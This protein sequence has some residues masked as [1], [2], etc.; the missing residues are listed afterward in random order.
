MALKKNVLNISTYNHSAKFIVTHRQLLL[1]VARTELKARYAGSI[2]GLGWAVA[3]PLLMLIIYALVYL[4][5]F[6]IRVPGLSPLQYVLLIFSG[7]VPFFTTSE[8]LVS[9][10]S[11]VVSNK[12][13]LS[14]TVFPI[15]LTPV[16]AVLLSQVTMVV[17]L[18][19]I[20]MVLIV[21]S[22]LSWTIVLLPI[23][24]GLQILALIGLTWI[25]SLINLV[26]RDL[27]TLIGLLLFI[28]M[29]VS[30]IAY[31]PEMVPTSLK[32][33]VILNPFAYFVMAYQQ[34]LVLGQLPVWW[35]MLGV[36][37]V[38]IGLFVLGGHFFFQAKRILIDYV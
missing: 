29:V 12:S 17:G 7:L 30:P 11:S 13:V 31:T 22:S 3:F 32:P 2:F 18:S 33:L 10:V 34:I 14:N 4:I 6:Q 19:V 26:F 5:I 37:V 8:A 21:T 35:N 36:L 16:K 23:I 27:Q 38:S 15:D 25:L 1:R 28:L 9:G 24:W 20:I